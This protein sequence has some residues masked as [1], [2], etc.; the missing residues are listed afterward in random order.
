MAGRKASPNTTNRTNLSYLTLLGP[1][2]SAMGGDDLADDGEAE[3]CALFPCRPFGSTG[4]EG[5]ED[6]VKVGWSQTRAVVAD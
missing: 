3:S 1:D 4:S 2:L 5:F 6:V